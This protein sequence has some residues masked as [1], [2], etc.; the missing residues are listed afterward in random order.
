MTFCE[1][2]F[3]LFFEYLYVKLPSNLYLSIILVSNM[4]FI[5]SETLKTFVRIN[6]PKKLSHKII[7]RQNP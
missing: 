3:L 7:R 2:F 4:S 5:V 1:F 6:S